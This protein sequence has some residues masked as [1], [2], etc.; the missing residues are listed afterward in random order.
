M[1]HLICAK[2]LSRCWGK[3]SEKDRYTCLPSW[4]LH[5]TH[6]NQGTELAVRRPDAIFW[7]HHL[8]WKWRGRAMWHKTWPLGQQRWAGQIPQKE[9]WAGREGLQQNFSSNFLYI[10]QNSL[11]LFSLLPVYLIYGFK[12]I[13]LILPSLIHA[14]TSGYLN[15][16]LHLPRRYNLEK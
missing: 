1:E 4:N 5:S 8:G 10:I 12:N 2:D 14:R 11:T 9:V 15:T 3:D 13:L 16:L 7:H 6:R